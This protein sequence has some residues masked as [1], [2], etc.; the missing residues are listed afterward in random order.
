MP[1]QR[2]KTTPKALTINN[3]SALTMGKG[4][5]KKVKAKHPLGP[6]EETSIKQEKSRMR[7]RWD[8][9]QKSKKILSLIGNRATDCMELN[10]SC[11]E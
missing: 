1:C 3:R 10:R 8:E 11:S 5:N 6:V 9:D 4:K 7:G 2:V